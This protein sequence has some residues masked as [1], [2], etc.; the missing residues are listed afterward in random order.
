[1]WGA[2][3]RWVINPKAMIYSVSEASSPF[4]TSY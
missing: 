2:A 3:S 1:V 4:R